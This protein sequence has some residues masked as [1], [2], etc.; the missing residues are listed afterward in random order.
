MPTG[1]GQALL[2]IPA[3]ETKTLKTL[4]VHLDRETV[5]MIRAYIRHFLP[6]ARRSAGARPRNPHLFPGAD[7]RAPQDGG[8]DAGAGYLTRVKLNQ[9]FSRHMHKHCGL[10][11]CLHVMRHIAG[12]IILDQDPSAM[13]LVKE[14]LGHTRLETTEAYYAEVCSIV[15]QERYLH[16][17]EA[18]SRRVLA[19]TTFTVETGEDR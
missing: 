3:I 5:A 18:A 16:L 2:T 13:A 12:K 10:D 14:M 1:R 19:D 4:T 15:A 7:G 17:L 6:A 8:Y 11:M 9:T